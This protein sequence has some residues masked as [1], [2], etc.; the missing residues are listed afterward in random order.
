MMLP[1]ARTN[2][3]AQDRTGGIDHI[4]ERGKSPNPELGGH[5][6]RVPKWVPIR[7]KTTEK[8]TNSGSG[9]DGIGGYFQWFRR[10]VKNCKTFMRRF[11]PDPRL[12]NLLF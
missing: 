7:Q 2:E 4:Q 1:L 12:Q 9:F 8:S 3:P 5:E 10:G 6:L 11:D